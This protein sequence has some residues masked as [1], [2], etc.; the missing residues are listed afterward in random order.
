MMKRSTYYLFTCLCFICLGCAH[1]NTPMFADINDPAILHA[2]QRQLNRVI[3]YDV[4]TPPVASR[5]YAYTSLAAYEAVRFMKPGYP[6]LAAQF[7][8]FKRMPMPDTSKQYNYLL[9]SSVAFFTVAH[10]VVFSLDTLKK[11]E[12]GLLDAYKD[13]LDDETYS[14][15]VAFGEAVGNSVLER[16]AS[17]NYK[18]TRAMAKYL[19]SKADGKWQPTSPDYFDGVE[20]YWKMITP[21]VMDSAGQFKPCTPPTFSR[22]KNSAFFKNAM[23]VYN[24][25]KTLTDSQTTIIEYWDDNPFVMEHKGHMMFANKK[26]TPGG[27]WMGI[28]GIACKKNHTDPVK[29]AQV[30]AMT[31]VALLDGFIACWEEKYRSEVVR[32]VTVI[33]YMIDNKWQP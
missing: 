8:G 21:F 13:Q 33:N 27:H 18:K 29:T 5:I 12:A 17:D 24:I 19:G 26:I 3:I 22:E 11:Y 25:S 31:A 4:F 14:R 28:A 20:P 7:N 15:S 10:K 16:A 30:Y 9:A 32:P 6:S 2:N 1:R 23:E